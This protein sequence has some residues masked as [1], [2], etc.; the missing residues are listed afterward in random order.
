MM[1]GTKC[2]NC[3]HL[4]IWSLIWLQWFHSQPWSID[5]PGSIFCDDSFQL[6][7]EPTVID[8]EI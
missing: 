1:I 8:G 5:G 6:L 4:I 2:K 3:G 7:A